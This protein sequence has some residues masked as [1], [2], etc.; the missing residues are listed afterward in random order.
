MVYLRMTAFL[1][2]MH[3]LTPAVFKVSAQGLA[4][5]WAEPAHNVCT[6]LAC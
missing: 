5:D 6:S 2:L 1:H 3:C 4:I